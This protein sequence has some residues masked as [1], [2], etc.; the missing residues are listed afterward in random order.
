MGLGEPG[1]VAL[2]L[3]GLGGVP[4]NGRLGE[5]L[6]RGQNINLVGPGRSS[7]IRCD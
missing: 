3:A 6:D 4:E 5:I 1:A 7:V 2:L